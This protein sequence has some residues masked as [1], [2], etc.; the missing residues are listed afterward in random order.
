MVDRISSANAYDSAVNNLL[1]RQSQLSD[2]Q[3]QMTSGKRVNKASDDPTAAARAERARALQDRTTASEKAVDASSNAM[4]MT[5]SALGDAGDL[6]QQARELV[7]SAGDASYSDAERASKA[8]AIQA[9]RDQLLSVAT[10]TEPPTPVYLTPPGWST[11]GAPPE[12]W[13]ENT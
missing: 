4:T 11:N 10:L 1:E 12:P 2:T 9:I 5:E 13:P 7:V 6:L 8:K 3:I